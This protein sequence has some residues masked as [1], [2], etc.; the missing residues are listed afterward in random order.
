MKC[1]IYCSV[2]VFLNHVTCVK[3][4][5]FLLGSYHLLYVSLTKFLRLLPQ[6][7]FPHKCCGSSCV[8]LYSAMILGKIFLGNIIAELAMFCLEVV[9]LKSEQQLV[10]SRS[11]LQYR[12]YS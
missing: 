7:H 9:T 4:L 5:C 11:R 10:I 1:H 6:S 8:I 3:L 2:Y 12:T